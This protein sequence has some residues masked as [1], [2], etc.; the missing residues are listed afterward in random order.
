[1]AEQYK[2]VSAIS[3]DEIS[4]VGSKKHA[5]MNYRLQEIGESSKKNDYFAGIP[6]IAVGDFH[7]LSPPMDKWIFEF[8]FRIVN[9]GD[10]S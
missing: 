7:Q 8:D 3:I 10:L 9:P 1:M 5:I 2:D 6:S 4:M